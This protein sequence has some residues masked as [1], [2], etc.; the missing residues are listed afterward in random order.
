MPP[1][2]NIENTKDGT[3]HR[4]NFWNSIHAVTQSSG[5]NQKTQSCELRHCALC[6]GLIL[7]HMLEEGMCGALTE[8]TWPQ[9]NYTIS[10][11]ESSVDKK[12]KSFLRMHCDTILNKLCPCQ[13]NNVQD[14]NCVFFNKKTKTKNK[15]N[16]NHSLKYCVL[17]S[18][19]RKKYPL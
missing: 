13:C 6:C 17:F 8:I 2:R 1:L 15:K 12:K 3:E 18:L 5:M 10:V 7:M 19:K 16:N 14:V 4:Q 11:I 9:H